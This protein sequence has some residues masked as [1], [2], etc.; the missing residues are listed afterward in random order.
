M[1]NGILGTSEVPATTLTTVYTV[2]ADTFS[3]VTLNVVNRSTAPRTVRVALSAS[4]TPD[5]AEY[6][7]YDVEILANGVLERTGLVLDATK[8]IVVYADSLG[9]SA[10]VFGLETATS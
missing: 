3:V 4:A 8:N 7:E 9:C 1:A 6:I 5:L 2:P 10:V